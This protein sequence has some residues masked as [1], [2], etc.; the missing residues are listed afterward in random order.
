MTT[1]LPQKLLFL[2]AILTLLGIVIGYC[3]AL[4]RAKHAARKAIE[5]V[6][7][8][9]TQEQHAVASELQTA[10]DR[11]QQLRQDAGQD[12]DASQATN[13]DEQAAHIEALEA[14]IAILEDKQLRLQRDFASYK[15]TKTRQLELA[16]SAS[17]TLADTHDLPT[18]SRRVEPGNGAMRIRR[19]ELDHSLTSNLDIPTL[20]E[21]ELSDSWDEVEFD[22]VDTGI[23]EAKPGG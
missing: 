19:D 5:L 8:E 10:T 20:A 11:A 12:D 17:L 3:I 13:P 15:T 21:S 6:R 14:Q 7:L 22:F 4:I 23:D 16:R 18:L 1:D 9:L 2:L